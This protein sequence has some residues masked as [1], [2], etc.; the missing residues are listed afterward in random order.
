MVLNNTSDFIRYDR[1]G[2]KDM[3]RTRIFLAL[4]AA[5]IGLTLG[6]CAT[7]NNNRV[8]QLES[9]LNQTQAQLMQAQKEKADIEMAME[10]INSENMAKQ[11]PMA[12][13]DTGSLLPPDAVA[14]HCYARVLT[15]ATYQS[16]QKKVLV[17]EPTERVEVIPA[18]YEWTEQRVL[19]KEESVQ[20]KLVPARHEWKTEQVLVRES[21]EQ[22]V[23]IPATYKTVSE[24][25]MVKPAYTTWKKGRGPIERIDN[26][27][28]EIMCL[29]DVPAQYKT[30]SRQ[31]EVTP[32]RTSKRVIPAEY[33]TVKRLVMVEE[34]RMTTVTI[35]AEYN[36]VKVKKLASQA[37]EK[38]YT[39]PAVYSTIT[40]QSKVSDSRMEWRSI[41]C[42]TNTTP[43]VV[44]RIQAALKQKGYNPGQID[45]VIGHET[46]AALKTYQR[47]SRLA[48]GQLT[49]KTME[50]LG[51]SL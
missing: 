14:G 37:E 38:R 1:I 17:H 3:N 51:V 21:S 46:L 30:V 40:E 20:A 26:S 49:I 19:V 6:G 29:V 33:K 7:T 34:P 11:P 42:E 48:E 9:E 23:E 41:L 15:P 32:A 44:K 16:V 5:T 10:E 45:G 25:V 50:S 43:G 4:G 2:S 8:T 35:P 31:V 28:G 39:I 24:Q 36:V 18:R 27:T 47:D 13:T 12:S 22:L